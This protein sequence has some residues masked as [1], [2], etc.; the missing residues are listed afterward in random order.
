MVLRLA[1]P[2]ARLAFVA[3][4][5]VVAFALAFFSMRNAWAVQQTATRKLAGLQTAAGLE[6]GDFNNWYLLGRYWQYSLEEP[7]A[8][9]AIANFRHSLS[10][11]PLAAE[12]WLDL[13]SVYESQGDISAAR[14]AF[15]QARRVHPLSAAVAWQYGNFLLRQDQVDA[16]FA[17]IRRAT[18]IEPKRSAE[19]FSRCWRVNPDA[20]AVV[21]AVIPPDRDAYLVVMRELA[22]SNEVSAALSIWQRLLAL[23][24]RMNPPDII[25]FTDLLI[26]R[27][28]MEEARRIWDQAVQLSTITLNDPP[29]SVVWDGGFE[30]NLSGG[31]FAWTFPAASVG[32]QA[33]FDPR[34]KHSGKKS[35]RLFFDGEHNASYDGVCNN[36]YVQPGTTYRFSAW[37]RAQALTTDEG[38]RLRLESQSDRGVSSR[39]DSQDTRGTQPWTS[40]EM[41]WT[42]ADDVRRARVC[43]VRIASRGMNP[44]IQGTI[45]VDDIALVPVGRSGP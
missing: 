36:L 38:V 11:N 44:H 5:A 18:Y 10:L 14:D 30:S 12:V 24:P 16:A 43:V 9:L 21:D 1:T 31:G 4:S 37:V 20:N 26:Q 27:R 17:E 45:W 29:N 6:P 41:S 42:S 28:R 39:V 13:A 19:A 8:S 22:S 33:A 32:V 15:L 25:F 7:N 23:R 35:L 2:P 40:M 34:Q 3:V